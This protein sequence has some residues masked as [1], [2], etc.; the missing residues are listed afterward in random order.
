MCA[1][2]LSIALRCSGMFKQMK[3]AEFSLKNQTCFTRRKLLLEE[4][5][6]LRSFLS[7]NK[8]P[9]PNQHQ[10]NPR[11]PTGIQQYDTKCCLSQEYILWKKKSGKDEEYI[12]NKRYHRHELTI[13]LPKL[14]IRA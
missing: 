10:Q 13:L 3:N 5:Q 14:Y 2:S 11:K 12:S 9:I 7:P 1:S 8:N 6:Q 4:I